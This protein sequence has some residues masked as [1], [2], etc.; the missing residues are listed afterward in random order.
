LANS[1]HHHTPLRSNLFHSILGVIYG[2]LVLASRLE[3]SQTPL[4]NERLHW[5]RTFIDRSYT[6]RRLWQRWSKFLK[7]IKLLLRVFRNGDCSN[8]SCF[9]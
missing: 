9:W 7:S 2:F 1:L 3:A 8:L 5:A 4:T 6:L